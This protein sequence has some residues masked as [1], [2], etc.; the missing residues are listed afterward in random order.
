MNT[1]V[2]YRNILM[3]VDFI[4]NAR[5]QANQS[6]SNRKRQRHSL[7]VNSNSDNINYDLGPAND[8][9]SNYVRPE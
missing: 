1:E 4:M 3:Q 2:A 6:G 5:S 7:D 9:Y 8:P